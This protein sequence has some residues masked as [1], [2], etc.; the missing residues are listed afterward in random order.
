M[1]G[2]PETK[3][4]QNSHIE[5]DEISIH[6]SLG[7]VNHLTNKDYAAKNFNSTLNN[8]TLEN[9]TDKKLKNVTDS[10]ATNNNDS[11]NSVLYY[12]YHRIKHKNRNKRFIENMFDKVITYLNTSDTPTITGDAVMSNDKALSNSIDYFESAYWENFF[13]LKEWDIAISKLADANRDKRSS[14]RQE[15]TTAGYGRPPDV[16]G[17]EVQAESGGSCRMGS[18]VRS[19]LP[20][21]QDIYKFTSCFYCY[22]FVA[23]HRKKYHLSLNPY[24]VYNWTMYGFIYKVSVSAFLLQMQ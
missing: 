19:T 15:L 22:V 12:L 16:I 9:V 6:N 14:V 10:K 5:G 2:V 18:R 24:K 23:P 11:L 1:F 8:Q 13:K 17:Q 21:A 4:K 3:L 20:L 7:Y